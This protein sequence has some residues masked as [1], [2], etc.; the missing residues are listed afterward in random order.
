MAIADAD[1]LLLAL[2]HEAEHS[3]S[4]MQGKQQRF[5]DFAHQELAALIPKAPPGVRNAPHHAGGG[6]NKGRSAKR[7][8]ARKS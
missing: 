5:A 2:K 4:N 8:N 1:R 6:E 3:F 7:I